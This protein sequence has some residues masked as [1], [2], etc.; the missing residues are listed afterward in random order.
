MQNT[1]QV[2][3]ETKC[4]AQDL[5]FLDITMHS[6][7]HV[8]STFIGLRSVTS[9]TL[10]PDGC[11]YQPNIPPPPLHPKNKSI[12]YIQWNQL[13]N[14]L[15]EELRTNYI[16]YSILVNPVKGMTNPYLCESTARVPTFGITF[17]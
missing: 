14:S 13:M 7:R 1:N 17:L 8:L 9:I 15:L 3:F 6:P 16:W 11:L 12:I 4:P 2:D 5:I 10:N